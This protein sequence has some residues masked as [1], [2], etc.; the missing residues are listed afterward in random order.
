MCLKLYLAKCNFL[1]L[2]CV[3]Q[4]CKNIYLCI[5]LQLLKIVLFEKLLYYFEVEIFLL[6]QFV[7]FLKYIGATFCMSYHS[8]KM[9]LEF[10]C[11]F[12]CCIYLKWVENNTMLSLS[13]SAKANICSKN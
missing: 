9:Q 10:L 2:V 3:F 13:P 6:T 1:A 12:D 11:S 5:E 8:D 4:I 7:S